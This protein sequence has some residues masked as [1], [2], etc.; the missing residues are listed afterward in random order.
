[1]VELLTIIKKFSR[2]DLGM[3]EEINSSVLSLLSFRCLGNIFLEIFRRKL[4][5]HKAKGKRLPMTTCYFCS[6]ALVAVHKNTSLLCVFNKTVSSICHLPGA[7]YI[8]TI[9]MDH[10]DN[11]F[12]E[13]E[14]YAVWIIEKAPPAF[15]W[16]FNL[17]LTKNRWIL[18]SQVRRTELY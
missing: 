13:G 16:S 7:R 4:N 17:A 6:L 11:S 9:V 15:K 8:I 1:M 3:K 5:N 12:I 2:T 18:A 14:S 10:S